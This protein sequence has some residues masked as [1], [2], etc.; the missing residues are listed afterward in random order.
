MFDGRDGDKV[1]EVMGRDEGGKD[2]E[3]EEAQGPGRNEA[4]EG[5]ETTETCQEREGGTGRR[6]S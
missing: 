4:C 5:E 2:M 3:L 1:D 6:R